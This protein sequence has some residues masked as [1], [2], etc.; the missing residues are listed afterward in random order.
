VRARLHDDSARN[1]GFHEGHEE[2]RNASSFYHAKELLERIESLL[3][4]IDGLRDMPDIAAALTAH[5]QALA[6]ITPTFNVGEHI[7]EMQIALIRARP[8]V[9]GRGD[10]IN[11]AAVRH[12]LAHVEAA[13]R[14][15]A[16]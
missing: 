15:L 6:G 13:K 1:A 9:E 5:V 16:S 11:Q 4:F 7:H 10:P 8:D 2:G 14:K 12:A 3:R